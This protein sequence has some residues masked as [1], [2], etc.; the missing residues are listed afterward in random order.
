MSNN[1]TTFDP[2]TSSV[3]YEFSPQTQ[4]TASPLCFQQVGTRD[5]PNASSHGQIAVALTATN[6]LPLQQ[7]VFPTEYFPNQEQVYNFNPDDSQCSQG[8][9]L[10]QQYCPPGVVFT[11]QQ[12]E[13][14]PIQRPAQF[15]M[16]AVH[17]VA[18]DSDHSYSRIFN[19]WE[20]PSVVTSPQNMMFPVNQYGLQDQPMFRNT[21]VDQSSKIVRHVAVPLTQP[22]HGYPNEVQPQVRYST[23]QG[24]IS[25]GTQYNGDLECMQYERIENPHLYKNTMNREPTVFISVPPICEQEPRERKWWME[26]KL[27]GIACME[28]KDVGKED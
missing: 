20:D 10:P 19:Y 1:H 24:A 4:R 7:R 15:P 6:G 3:F 2:R 23:P 14:F 25:H 18:S 13:Y 17:P 21:R 26:L 12:R 11:P 8:Q 27:L 5:G 22:D 28:N 16:N 9:V